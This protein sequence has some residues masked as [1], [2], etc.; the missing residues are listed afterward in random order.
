[1]QF[2]ALFCVCESLGVFLELVVGG[3]SVSENRVICGILAERLSVERD[4]PLEILILEA[5]VTLV[6]ESRH[7]CSKESLLVFFYLQ[8]G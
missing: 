1:M 8:F 4:R 5:I 3:A 6:F 2:D 7:I